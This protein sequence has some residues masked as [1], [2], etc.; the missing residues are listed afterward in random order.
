MAVSI[1]RVSRIWKYIV[2]VIFITF[3]RTNLCSESY[4]TDIDMAADIC[5][6][7]QDWNF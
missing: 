3:V 1:T 4:L 6:W 2:T 5:F 7:L